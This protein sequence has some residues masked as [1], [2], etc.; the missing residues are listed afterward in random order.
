MMG[1]MNRFQRATVAKGKGV[2]LLLFRLCRRTKATIGN[3]HL[4]SFRFEPGVYA[5]VGSAKGKGKGGLAG[6]LLRHLNLTDEKT[7]KWNIDKLTMSP[8]FRPLGAITFPDPRRA[9]CRLIP[10]LR[11]AVEIEVAAP[12]FGS[13]D[14][15]DVIR[16]KKLKRKPCKT[17]TWRITGRLHPEELAD[18][19]GGEWCP[20]RFWHQLAKG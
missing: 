12:G 4:R 15:D 1:C 16:R 6:R 19:M 13:H 9:E 18:S 2:Y 17:H 3:K 11:K 7:D 8:H 10:M 20:M 5:Y 14:D